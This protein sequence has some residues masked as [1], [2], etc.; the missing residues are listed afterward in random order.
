MQLTIHSALLNIILTKHF[1]KLRRTRLYDY[2]LREANLLTVQLTFQ[3]RH[4]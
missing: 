2:F 4:F 3:C 1:T